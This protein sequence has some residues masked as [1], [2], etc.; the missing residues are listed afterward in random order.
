MLNLNN[1][2]YTYQNLMGLKRLKNRQT[3]LHHIQNL[4]S[5][6]LSWNYGTF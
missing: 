2:I 4:G 3:M 1:L 5:N 6:K